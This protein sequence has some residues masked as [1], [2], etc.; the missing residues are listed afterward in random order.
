MS[1][2]PHPQ[3]SPDRLH[4]EYRERDARSSRTGRRRSVSFC[5]QAATIRS[6]LA[7]RLPFSIRTAGGR[8]Y[9]VRH[10]HICIDPGGREVVV[11]GDDGPH[12]IP[13]LRVVAVEVLR[14][15]DARS[16]G[17]GPPTLA[18]LRARAEADPDVADR[19]PC[20]PRRPSS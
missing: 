14:K 3:L 17:A 18:Q 6:L 8:T 20:G 7:S 4:R 11:Y 2:E 1:R 13:L 19:Q 10:P 16:E 5:P 9:V 12:R 15:D